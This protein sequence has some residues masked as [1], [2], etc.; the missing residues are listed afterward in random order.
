MKINQNMR[1]VLVTLTVASSVMAGCNSEGA[2]P[3][4]AELAQNEQSVATAKAGTDAL[5]A[6]VGVEPGPVLRTEG[7]AAVLA[8]VEGQVDVRRLGEE[9]FS[10]IKRD[11]A[12]YLGDQ[13]RTGEGAQA[14][15]LFADESSAQLAELSIL[16]VGSRVATADPASSAALLSGVARFSVTP[17]APGEGPFMVFTPAGV[18]A[19]KGTV[20]GVGVAAD[21]DARVGVESGAVEVAG[22]IAL[23]APITL[24]ASSAAELSAAGKV[25]SATAWPADDWGVWRDQA[26]ADIDVAAT[27]TLHADAMANLATQLDAGYS[28]LADLSAQVGKFEAE[29]AAQAS[30][31][32]SAGYVAALP[33]AS[34]DIDA[35]FLVAL[36]LEFLTHAYAS[37]AA[38]AAELYLRHPE[39]VVWPKVEAH[40]QAG[41]LWP[42]RLDAMVVA[43]FE[44][45]R[46][47]YYLHHPRGRAHAQW[48]GIAVPAFYASVTPPA[49]D[50]NAN[51]K[52]KFKVFTPPQVAFT[53]TGRAVWVAAPSANWQGKV[54]LKGTAPRGKLAFWVRPPKL[55][56]KAVLG[57]SVKGKINSGF[58]VRPPEARGRLKAQWGVA[59]GQK[60]KLSPPDLKA[61]AQ[62][63][64]GWNANAAPPDLNAKLD[65]KFA[66]KGELPDIKG[67]LKASADAKAKLA[68]DGRAKAQAQANAAANAKAKLKAG[69][70]ASAKIKV[71]MPEIKPPSAKA[72]AKGSAKFKLGN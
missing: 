10:S 46:L 48:V 71:K 27:A 64:A 51:M 40:V 41:V 59:L 2:K 61:S 47:Q 62:A 17:R 26:E 21:G 8:A 33:E 63:R 5:V 9:A 43:Y 4:G 34:L 56:A 31:N 35:S 66:A 11:D 13:I 22:A 14:T 72:E 67:K 36:R 25:G 57:G 24:E 65:A 16:A 42:K 68:A 53:A 28:A 45:L 30:S 18:I 70:G 12:L 19:T 60:I 1:R 20:F 55:R 49:L 58:A 44:P 38:L 69:A 32:N 39:L 23:D 7:A 50:A 54:K 29:A 37:H 3:T 15:V 6:Q 52:L